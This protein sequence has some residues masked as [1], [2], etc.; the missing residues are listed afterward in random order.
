MADGADIDKRQMRGAF[1]RAATHYDQVARLQREVAAQLL[2]RLDIIRVEPRVILDIG[3]GTGY[4]S[5]AVARR[6]RG[7]RVLGVD[8]AEAMAQRANATT[9]GLAPRAQTALGLRGPRHFVCAD[10]EALPLMPASVDMAVSN[11]TLQWCDARRVFAEVLR[12][13]KPGGL[14]MFATLGPDTLKELRGAWQAVDGDVH[15]HQFV[16]M[17]DIGDW[18][19]AD[20]FT[21]PV[22]DIERLRLGY[23]DVTALLRELKQLGAHNV[24]TS[25]RRALTGRERFERFRAAYPN[26]GPDGAISATYEVVF[27]HGWAPAA[28]RLAQSSGLAAVP[29]SEVKRLHG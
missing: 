14:F 17:H 9:K 15:V 24:A 23:A 12:V 8:I 1:N 25:R 13:L 11:L 4:L 3:C 16:D 7:A 29:L 6:Y 28:V 27:G 21:D 18:M 19:L 5:A 20:G 2:E 22:L 10:A 26:D